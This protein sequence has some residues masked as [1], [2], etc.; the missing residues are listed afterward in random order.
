MRVVPGPAGAGASGDDA[1][2]V[3]LLSDLVEAAS[4]I[5]VPL[6]AGGYAA[7]EETGEAANAALL[8]TP[9]GAIDAV[10][11]KRHLVPGIEAGVPGVGGLM[12]FLGWTPRRGGWLTR[13]REP[14]TFLLDGRRLGVLICYESAFPSAV[15]T[16]ATRG[17]EAFVSLTHEGWFGDGWLGAVPREQHIAHLRL[18][19]V[20]SRS[21][22]LR[23]AADGE[24]LLLD[25]RGRV[26]ARGGEEGDLWL[27]GTLEGVAGLSLQA[28]FGH[29]TGGG[30]LLLVL[31]LAGTAAA[32]GVGFRERG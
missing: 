15:R 6:L 23:S 14:G 28:R 20:E 3:A 2:T 4:E 9:E 5:G 18:R 7:S 24:A 12:E 27:T 30:L 32:S 22:I 1:G 25:P 29:H 13:G 10:H 31:A 26:T 11:Q 17:A 8:F 19:A 16:P 21:G